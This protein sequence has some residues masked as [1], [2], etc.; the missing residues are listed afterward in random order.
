M[1]PSSISGGA[2]ASG[3]QVPGLIP[4]SLTY[5]L[6]ESGN[7]LLTG[8]SGSYTVAAGSGTFDIT[9]KNG[10]FTLIGVLTIQN[11]TVTGGSNG[12]INTTIVANFNITGGTY[13][14][15]S[16]STCGTGVGYGDAFITMSMSCGSNNV[17]NGCKAG[18]E[19][20]NIIMPAGDLAT[21]PEPSSMLLFGTGLLGCGVFLRRR[22]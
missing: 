5:S 9:L 2:L 1:S 11:L 14:A 19:S 12:Q 4:S 3:T 22:L 10:S 21:T 6:S 18:L 8:S 15:E 7:I 20:I 16:G 13:C 17:T